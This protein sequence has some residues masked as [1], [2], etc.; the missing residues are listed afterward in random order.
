[1]PEDQ[2]SSG[3]CFII[4]F[5]KSLF[6][7]KFFPIIIFCVLS[8]SSLGCR[9][10]GLTDLVAG[11]GEVK[12]KGEPCADA[13]LIFSPVTEGGEN[14]FS[15]ARTDASGKFVIE[16]N[17]QQGILP[18]K[19]AVT[20]FKTTKVQRRRLEE[21]DKLQEERKSVFKNEKPQNLLP[22][23]YRKKE[24]SGLTVDIDSGGQHNILLELE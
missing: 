6:M 20:V 7:K 3:F 1:M 8:L 22:E 10:D 9:N 14:R 24:T 18:G 11:S 13:S 19:Y 21:E 4:F 12:F 16:T 5:M 2:Y 23:K 17:G 15:T